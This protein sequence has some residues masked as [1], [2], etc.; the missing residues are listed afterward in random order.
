MYNENK[1]LKDILNKKLMKLTD[2]W[3]IPDLA[4]PSGPKNL[5]WSPN[6]ISLDFQHVL[7]AKISIWDN[8]S[9]KNTATAHQST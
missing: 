8:T 6:T 5:Q 1:K 7:R 9:Q 4:P 3:V 2:N